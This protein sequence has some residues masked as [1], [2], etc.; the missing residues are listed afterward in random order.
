MDE[1]YQA[2][3]ERGIEH[4]RRCADSPDWVE[5][6]LAESREATVIL[7][8]DPSIVNGTL[9]GNLV[10]LLG[11]V[12]RLREQRDEA[13]HTGE[14]PLPPE[15]LAAQN[16]ALTMPRPGVW[17]VEGEG[18]ARISSRIGEVGEPEPLRV[19]AAYA[20]LQPLIEVLSEAK[21]TGRD[22]EILLAEDVVEY[23]ARHAEPPAPTTEGATD[24]PESPTPGAAADGPGPD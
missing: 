20:H 24:A 16:M 5:K 1:L 10:S 15:A 22:S 4:A 12:E 8:A 11:L 3:V 7:L 13:L 6:L 9:L 2:M 14:F 17:L 23:L 21:A 19:A 18:P